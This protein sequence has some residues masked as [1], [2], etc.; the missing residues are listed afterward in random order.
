[1]TH[2]PRWIVWTAATVVFC[3]AWV[4]LVYLPL[5]QQERREAAE[6]AEWQ[7]KVEEM[8]Q[9]LDAVPA[10]VARLDSLERAVADASAVLPA[11]DSL[12]AFLAEWTALGTSRGITTLKVEPELASMMALNLP[13]NR[14]SLELDTLLVSLSA[15][16]SFH[17]IGGWLDELEAQPAFRFWRTG[18]WDDGEEPGTVRFSG[19]AAILVAVPKGSNS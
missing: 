1:M 4:A 13:S 6:H 2:R 17:R 14:S 3:A 10:A 8:L 16:G 9:R 15:I 18:R 12:E 5:L 19:S 11:G 7:T